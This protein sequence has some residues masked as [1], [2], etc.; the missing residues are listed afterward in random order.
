MADTSKNL[1]LRLAIFAA[2]LSSTA[3]AASSL[4]IALRTDNALTPE[5]AERELAETRATL[6]QASD[7]NARAAQLRTGILR[8]TGI[9]LRAPR[10]IGAVRF[11]EARQQ[12]GYTAR[13]FAIE[14]LPGFFCT[15]TWYQP[16]TPGRHAAVLLPHGHFKSEGGGR[17]Q[18]D[19]QI[20]AATLARAGAVVCA[21]DMVGWG[22]CQQYPHR[23][24]LTLSLQLWDSLCLVDFLGARD[25]V[26]PARIAITGASG[27]GTQ[28]FLLAAVD[29]RIA[30][31]VPV[32]QV[33]PYFF[34]GCPC[35]SGLPIHQQEN[36]RTN[37]VEIA[38]LAAPRPQL[39][40]TDGKDW[41][42]DTPR[43]G[44][45]FLQHVYTLLGARDAIA[46]AHFAAEGHDYGPSKRRAAVEFLTARLG[47]ALAP[48]WEQRAVTIESPAAMS[49]W[50]AGARPGETPEV[51][52]TIAE[53]FR[54]ALFLGSVP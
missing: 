54:G 9:D 26:D 50:A 19:I 16:A 12:E 35:E 51:A 30:V 25:D 40:V 33:S 18:P 52:R 53:K 32:V 46:G 11:T 10:R 21:Y 47:L 45:P 39:V 36:Y 23:R 6:R 42:Q 44:L 41:T 29:D 28:A 24:P 49:P 38:A 17:F 2:L 14:T 34:G 48:G 31:S 1:L 20:L 8:A 3:A 7:W 15:G 43:L 27:G 5:Q 4:T 22:D 37:N 13:N